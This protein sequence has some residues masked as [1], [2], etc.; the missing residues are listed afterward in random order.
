MEVKGLGRI[1]F[2][3]FVYRGTLIIFVSALHTQAPIQLL[4][5]P[6]SEGKRHDPRFM[7]EATVQRHSP[8]K[9]ETRLEVRSAGLQSPH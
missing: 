2:S 9:A 1:F 4:Q 7:G 5:S 6:C 8:E 3:V